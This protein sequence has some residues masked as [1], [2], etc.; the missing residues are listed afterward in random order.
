MINAVKLN[1]ARM[2]RKNGGD[3]NR[4]KERTYIVFEDEI[5]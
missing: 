2:G 5:L 1:S 3:K 4:T